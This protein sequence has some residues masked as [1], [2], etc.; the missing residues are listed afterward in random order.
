MKRLVAG[1]I[2]EHFQSVSPVVVQARASPALG[3]SVVFGI[4]GDAVTNAHVV[5]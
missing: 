1:A 3:W 4:R 5:E 2:P